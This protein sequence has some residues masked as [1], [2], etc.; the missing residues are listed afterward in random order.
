MDLKQHFA[1]QHSLSPFALRTFRSASS[2]AASHFKSLG[3]SSSDTFLLLLGNI[4]QKSPSEI[5]NSN[6]RSV[7]APLSGY[8]AEIQFATLIL[9]YE[10][11]DLQQS[12]SSLNE[13]TTALASRFARFSAQKALASPSTPTH[14]HSHLE[15]EQLISPIQLSDL[16]QN[17]ARFPQSA[18]APVPPLGLEQIHDSEVLDAARLPSAEEEGEVNSN[19]FDSSS[20]IDSSHASDLENDHNS[21]LDDEPS[22]Q[23]S[24]NS[25]KRRHQEVIPHR[26]DLLEKM[27]NVPAKRKCLPEVPHSI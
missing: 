18:S 12:G 24:N 4:C 21:D 9:Y 3:S 10:L 13:A 1:I 8:S 26:S 19:D 11:L 20:S 5:F 17:K 6:F 25:R 23:Q 14:A 27:K 22:S 16:N 15:L 7:L 2:T